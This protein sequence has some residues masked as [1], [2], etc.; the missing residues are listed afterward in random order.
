MTRDRR[1]PLDDT[2]IDGLDERINTLIN[3][4][5][6]SHARAIAQM[7][8]RTIVEV[9]H[10]APL[11][12]YDGQI[13]LADGVNWNPAALPSGYTPYL[14]WY[15]DGAWHELLD[16]RHNTLTPPGYLD[17]PH[18]QYW[19][20]V[21]DPAFAHIYYQDW[22]V[23]QTLTNGQA[24]GNYTAKAHDDWQLISDLVAG[25]ITVDTVSSVK[26]ETGVYAFAMSIVAEGDANNT[27]A[28]TLYRNGVAGVLSVPII[29]K[30]NATVGQGSVSGTTFIDETTI[31]DMRLETGTDLTILQANLSLHRISP[32]AGTPGVVGTDVSENTPPSTPVPPN[33]GQGG[34]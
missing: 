27:Y 2:P 32:I 5:F 24:L 20:K 9:R 12:A 30:G 18:T 3:E 15:W 29:L 7:Q 14:V 10:V 34:P 23:G 28:M 13:E 16:T 6:R 17:D 1:A 31:V 19:H 4:R 22:D 33:L 11:R 25:T 21:L 8:A 26:S